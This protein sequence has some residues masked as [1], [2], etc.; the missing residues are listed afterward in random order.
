MKDNKSIAIY[1]ASK[2][3]QKD[4]TFDFAIYLS[5]FTELTEDKSKEDKNEV[6]EMI[7]DFLSEIRDYGYVNFKENY[8]DYKLY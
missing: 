3:F 1:I 6:L 5:D 8:N 7:G 2:M 4:I